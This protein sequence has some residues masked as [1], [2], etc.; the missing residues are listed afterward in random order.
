[1]SEQVASFG[2]PERLPEPVRPEDRAG[3]LVAVPLRNGVALDSHAV[4]IPLSIN[5]NDMV[6][7]IEWLKRDCGAD[8]IRL[9]FH[10]RT[11]W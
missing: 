10:T 6:S 1:M 7:Q 11:V 3:L 8:D 4:R 5:W 9:E 2:A